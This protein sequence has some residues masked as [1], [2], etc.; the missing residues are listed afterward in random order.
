MSIE[1]ATES[2]TSETTDGWILRGDLLRP[3]GKP[4]AVAVLGHAM[5]V[6]RQTMD[7]PRGAGLAS[8]LVGQGLVVLNFDVR[9]HGESGPT[10]REGA[11]WTYDD[12]VRFDVPALIA[13]GRA[14]FPELPVAIVGHS[15]IGH[16]AEIHAGLDPNA[17]ADAIV[18]FGGNLWTPELE[19]AWWARLVKGGVLLVWAALARLPGR[20]F[21]IGTDAEPWPYV[22]QFLSMYF[23]NRMT[24]P[25]GAV[26]Y[27]HALERVCIPVLAFS[28][29]GDWLLAR[30]PAVARFV[31]LMKR[32]PVEHRVL[33][34]QIGHPTPGHMD[35]VV[36]SHSRP[37]WEEAGRWILK[38]I[39]R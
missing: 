32:A 23:R 30:P 25:D 21:R 29:E 37:Q 16:A 27:A 39:S 33:H 20:F 35:L 12:I 1:R 15:L 18:S 22:R 31:S 8:T 36:S 34:T 38:T 13:A 14:R 5:M 28:S 4:Q 6:N 19:P 2:I 7:R 10:A 26:D 17:A 9:G 3:D 11:T 24:S